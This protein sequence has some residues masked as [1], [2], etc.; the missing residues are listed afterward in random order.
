MRVPPEARKSAQGESEAGRAILLPLFLLAIYSARRSR[1]LFLL[2]IE[3]LL[4]IVREEAN[5][6][7]R[8]RENQ[9]AAPT[10]ERHRPGL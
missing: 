8:E 1:K 10:A 2:G 9:L 7:E 3:G 5:E 4:A 6:R